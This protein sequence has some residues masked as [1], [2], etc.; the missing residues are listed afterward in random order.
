MIVIGF[1]AKQGAGKTTAVDYMVKALGREINRLFENSYEFQRINI[2]DTFT[3][4]V[5]PMFAQ[6]GVDP[7]ANA[8]N[9]GLF[10]KMQLAVSTTFESIN[11][12]VWSDKWYKMVMTSGV[13]HCGAIF[14][15]DIRTKMN[16]DAM[17]DLDRAFEV[18]NE[19][20]IEQNQIMYEADMVRPW[21]ANQVH[22]IHLDC[23]TEIRKQRVPPAQW[24]PEDNYTEMGVDLEPYSLNIHRVSTANSHED[25]QRQLDDIIQKIIR[26]HMTV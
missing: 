20:E 16:V 21:L 13:G 14:T 4:L 12:T 19:E 15:D 1:H 26:N 8:E 18:M 25:T 9:L 7:T 3:Q 5:E 17:A 11:P 10:K 6:M 23:P 2:K 22:L 24:R